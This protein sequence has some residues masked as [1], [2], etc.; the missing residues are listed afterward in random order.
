MSSLFPSTTSGH[1]KCI[2]AGEHIVLRGYPALVCPIKQ[3]KLSL[4]FIP[5][6]EELRVEA[7]E[8]G[9]GKLAACVLQTLRRSAAHVREPST[10]KDWRG[11]F[12]VRNGIE[13]GA[14]IGFSAA[15]CV[16]IARWLA[17]KGWI[18]EKRVF[19][20]AHRLE[21]D[22]HGRSSGL[23]VAGAMSEHALCFTATGQSRPLQCH[24]KPELYISHSGGSKETHEV[25]ASIQTQL[26]ERPSKALQLDEKMA[27]NV[28]AIERALAVK[29]TAGEPLLA[30]A[31]EGARLCFEAWGLITPSLQQH[32]ELLRNAGALA[33]KPTGAGK[34]G[35]VMSLWEAPP[36]TIE[37][38]TFIP[39]ALTPE[40]RHERLK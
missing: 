7:E 16:A 19:S 18:D 40:P 31:I 15:L 35:Y 8:E 25:I 23:D 37:G 1:A 20:V 12:Y 13:M 33:I 39:I 14:G 26:R 32:G 28:Y 21:A 6:G 5:G 24:W 29:R 2:L 27:G 17:S 4:A 11:A 3:K 9:D 38:V 34:G 22:Y 10:E 30:A 36:P